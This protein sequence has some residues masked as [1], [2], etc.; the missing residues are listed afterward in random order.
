[1]LDLPSAAEL[2]PSPTKRHKLSLGTGYTNFC[3]LAG[4]RKVY[5]FGGGPSTVLADVRWQLPVP[6][7]QSLQAA[8]M[9]CRLVVVSS[10]LT[11]GKGVSAA[12]A[13]AKH[14]EL[15]APVRADR[16]THHQ[17]GIPTNTRRWWVRSDK[18]AIRTDGAPARR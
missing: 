2:L 17:D 6:S 5:N 7:F 12:S 15:P 9:D 8:C 13:A 10:N 16:C 18:R 14:R 3:R 1:M 4:R 11:G